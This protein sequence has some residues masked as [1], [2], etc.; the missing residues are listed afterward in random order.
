MITA[1]IKK[2]I[3]KKMGKKNNVLAQ[4][5]QLSDISDQN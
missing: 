5:D 3:F 4:I 2:D 1:K